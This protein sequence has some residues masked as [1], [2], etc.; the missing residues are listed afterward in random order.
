MRVRALHVNETSNANTKTSA[1]A[2]VIKLTAY[3]EIDFL[4][5]CLSNLQSVLIN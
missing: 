2:K 5:N 3:T 4:F 1:T